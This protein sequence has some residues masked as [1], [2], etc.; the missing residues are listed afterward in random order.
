MFDGDTPG[1]R[2][3]RARAT[4]CRQRWYREET[5]GR[6]NWQWTFLVITALAINLIAYMMQ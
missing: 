3:A 5:L 2:I 6:P 4:H 1:T